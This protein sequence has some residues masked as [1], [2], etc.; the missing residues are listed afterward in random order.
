MQLPLKFGVV[1]EFK[2]GFAKVY[3]ADNEI[4]TGW[5]PVLVKTSL[6]DF[7]SWP[8]NVNEHVACLCGERCEEG[9]I[10]G[11][12]HSNPEPPDSGAAPGK[13]RKLFEDGTLLEYDKSA[14]KLTANVN[15]EV[16]VIAT[17]DINATSQTNI[18]AK[19]T[20][21]ASIEAPEIILKGAVTVEGVITA[22]GLA[23]VPMPSVASTP[24]GKV[25]G[26]INLTGTLKADSDVKVGTVSLKTH[27]HSGVQTGGGTSGLPVS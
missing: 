22:G 2:P 23:L 17:S 1:S 18:K 11:S 16:D 3:F 21:L 4:V 26:D 9:V 25:Q 6:K 8:L 5:W 7:E 12:I 15:G 24:D 10:L 27:I 13:F 20:I 14:H 19:A